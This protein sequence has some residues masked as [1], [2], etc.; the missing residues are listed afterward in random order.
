M[1]AS[2]VVSSIGAPFAITN[3][4][5]MCRWDEVIVVIDMQGRSASAL[6]QTY[7]LTAFEDDVRARGA[8]PVRYESEPRAWAVMNGCFNVGA[9][10]V[11]NDW[12]LFTHDDVTWMPYDYAKAVGHTVDWILARS[13]IA[14][15][16]Q[17]IVGLDLP[18][19]EVQH[20]VLV[21]TFPPDSPALLTQCVAPV[22]QVLRRAKLEEMGHFDEHF[23]VWY[24]GHLQREVHVR[25]WWFVHIPTPPALHQSNSSYKLNKWG[26]SWSANPKWGMYTENYQTMYGL[27]PAA[28]VLSDDPVV[29]DLTLPE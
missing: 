7:P 11:R 2:V 28:R 17:E 21:P 16:G 14:P 1:K 8:V 3:L 20:E 24:D 19:W 25:N 26:N 9:R 15:T 4:D 23:G 10:A 22:G 18:V 27:P 6:E 29:L 13:C 12:V 5:S